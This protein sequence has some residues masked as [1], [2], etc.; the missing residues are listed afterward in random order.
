MLNKPS[1]T[2]PSRSMLRL[3]G[4]G[5]EAKLKVTPI[6][7]LLAENVSGA[8]KVRKKELDWLPLVHTA[9]AMPSAVGFDVIVD[10]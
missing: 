10:S 3:A 9:F 8:I 4:S 2:K 1:P 5:V 7:P 6:E